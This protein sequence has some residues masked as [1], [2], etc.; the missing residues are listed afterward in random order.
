[1]SRTKYQ[2]TVHGAVA[3]YRPVD[4]AREHGLSTQAVRNYERDGVLPPA[5]RTTTGYRVYT[6]VHAGALRAHVALISAHGYAI[7]SEIMRSANRGDLDAVM[8]AIDRSH[9]QLHRDRETLDAVEAA[10]GSL[11]RPAADSRPDHRLRVIGQLA[12]RLNVTPATLR[13]WERAGILAPRRDPST[14]HRRYSAD[15]VR[16]ADLAHLLRRGGYPLNH[17]ATVLDHVRNAGGPEPLAASLGD[18]HQRL[19]SRGRAMLTAAGR[20]ADYLLLLDNAQQS[21]QPQH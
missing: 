18:W 12:H 15:D 14:G 7:S 5:L 21:E 20:L 1:M 6:A 3:R 8:R 13:K 4:L 19:A 17:I 2:T 9:N 10:I 11:T 16:D